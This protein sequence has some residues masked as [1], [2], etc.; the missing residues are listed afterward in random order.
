MT[1]ITCQSAPETSSLCFTKE[2]KTVLIAYPNRETVS[3]NPN[4]VVVEEIT[5]QKK[6]E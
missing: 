1:D 3:P 6:R 5:E 2:S 4:Q